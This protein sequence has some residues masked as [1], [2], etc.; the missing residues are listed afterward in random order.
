MGDL[1][2]DPTAAKIAENLIKAMVGEDEDST[3]VIGIDMATMMKDFVLRSMVTFSGDKFT[4]GMMESL[5]KE[6][7]GRQK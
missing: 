2:N 5:I 3:D 4:E 7:N 6:L 1:M